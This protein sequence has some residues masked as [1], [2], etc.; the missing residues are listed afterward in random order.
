MSACMVCIW[1][2][3]SM[4]GEERRAVDDTTTIRH[5]AEVETLEYFE[6][7]AITLAGD[8]EALNNLDYLLAHPY[9]LNTV[10][11][12]ELQSVP[13]ISPADALSFIQERQRL[14]RFRS[15]AQLAIIPG[16]GERLARRLS[17]FVAVLPDRPTETASIRTRA[18]FADRVPRAGTPGPTFDLAQRVEATLGRHA[19]VGFLYRR[20][21]AEDVAE[22]GISGYVELSDLPFVS[23][24]VVGDYTIQSGQG[25]VVWSDR[26]A[27]KGTTSS[28]GFRRAALGLEPSR[29]QSRSSFL[30]GIAVAGPSTGPATLCVFL[31]RRVLPGAEPAGDDLTGWRDTLATIAVSNL[32]TGDDVVERIAGARLSLAPL[33]GLLVGATGFRSQ[34]DRAI[35][36]NG[37]GVKRITAVSVGG[38]DVLAGYGRVHLFAEV[39]WSSMAGSAFLI[40]GLTQMAGSGALT[41]VWRDYVP[42]FFNPHASPLR[43]Y[44]GTLNER[45]FLASLEMPFAGAGRIGLQW[46]QYH[47]GEGSGQQPVTRGGH[48]I[49]VRC[50]IPLARGC[51]LALRVAS[52]LREEYL[53]D[54]GTGSVLRS[55]MG[56]GRAVRI[57]VGL[58]MRPGRGLQFQSR[59]EES[60][61]RGVRGTGRSGLVVQEIRWNAGPRLHVAGR[62]AFFGREGTSGPLYDMENDLGGVFGS[63]AIA[64]SGRRSSLVLNWEPAGWVAFAMKV[65]L[66][67]SIRR[68]GSESGIDQRIRARCGVFECQIRI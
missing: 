40:G 23:K 11:L 63:F 39:A 64:G 10:S 29:S 52:E 21:A 13:G 4:S 37:S 67:E 38:C 35:L 42:G 12:E 25:L 48:E 41:F 55:V 26:S 20:Q 34:F 19:V 7:S 49:A 27:L 24:I 30:R 50:Q 56:E 22:R 32:S 18:S 46:D 17:L 8:A 31:S 62:L 5:R 9:D 66:E 1:C 59:V 16:G 51:E 3:G 60:E 28:A 43:E 57:R 68:S 44:A 33:D 61:S 2:I 45:G 54:G 14:K 36:W 53:A 47:A 15:I 6:P 65:S 58:L